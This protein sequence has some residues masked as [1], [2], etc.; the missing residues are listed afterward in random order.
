MNLHSVFLRKDIYMPSQLN[1]VQRPCADNWMLVEGIEASVFD[2]MILH[3]GWHF[4]SLRESYR[5]SG[6][7]LSRDEAIYKALG[8]ALNGLRMRFNA[9]ELESIEVS[10]YP[11]FHIA[12]V[13]L[14]PCHVQQHASLETAFAKHA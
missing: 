3:A 2:T 5:R 9:A 14:Q 1:L 10:S 13:S 11:V 7:G 6:V 8:R 12:T 4:A